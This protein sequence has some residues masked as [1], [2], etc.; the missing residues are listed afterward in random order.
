MFTE[1]HVSCILEVSIIQSQYPGGSKGRWSWWLDEEM[2]SYQFLH[3]ECTLQLCNKPSHCDD[4]LECEDVSL[5]LINNF[6][7][8]FLPEFFQVSSPQALENMEI[9]RPSGNFLL[10]LPP[11]KGALTFLLRKPQMSLPMVLPL[12]LFSFLMLG[13]FRDS[14]LENC[15]N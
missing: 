5:I 1:D 13:S 7:I 15:E 10:F 6:S 9:S 8:K 3:K 11:T 14:L 2:V 12:S 4:I